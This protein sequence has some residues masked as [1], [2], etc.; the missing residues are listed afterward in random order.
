MMKYHEEPDHFPLPPVHIDNIL[1]EKCLRY[2][3]PDEPMIALA[4]LRYEDTYITAGAFYQVYTGIG[5]FNPDEIK[6]TV[7][8]YAKR[9]LSELYEQ[10]LEQLKAHNVIE[11]NYN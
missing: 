3:N 5:F 9:I 7:K 11:T 10:L 4:A 6:P 1:L 2:F 8:K